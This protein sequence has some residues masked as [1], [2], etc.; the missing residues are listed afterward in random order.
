VLSYLPLIGLLF[1]NDVVDNTQKNLLIFVTATLISERGE[2]LNPLAPAR[3]A[4]ATP[5]PAPAAAVTKDK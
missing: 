1:Q 4:A 3:P 5:A 2:N